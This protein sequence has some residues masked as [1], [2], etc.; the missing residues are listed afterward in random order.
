MPTYS[1][2]PL[3]TALQELSNRLFDSAQTFWSGPELTF[4]LQEALRTWNAMTGYWR[5]DF[6]FPA[7]NG[8][9]WYDLTDNVNLPNTLRPYTITDAYLYQIIQYHLL[10]P[11]TGVNPWTGVSNQFTAD[12]LINAVQRRRDEILAVCGCTLNRR[13]VPAVAG[14]TQLPDTVIDV[15][16]LS[17]QPTP[18]SLPYGRG[19]YGAG[20]Y[21][22]F[23]PNEKS[24]V[25]WPD[26][27][28]SERSF[29]RN[30]TINPAGTPQTY[31]MSTQPPIAF[32]T[33]APPAVPGNYELLTVEAGPLLSAATPHTLLIPDD[34][35]H[36]IKWG[37]L[38]DLLNRE[39][40]AKDQLR[41]KYCE[42]RYQ[43]GLALLASA[44]ALLAARIA[45]VA[46]QV[47][48]VRAADEFNTGWEAAAP[49][50]PQSALYAGLNLVA[51]TPI[52]DAGNYSVT[53]TVVENAP[54]PVV[55]GDFI[56]VSRDD[57]DVIIDYAQH[58]ASFKMGGAEFV[59][60]SPLLE[61][62]LAKAAV[63]GLKLSELGQYTSA[64]TALSQ[65]ETNLNPRM[66]PAPSGGP[67]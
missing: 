63:Y 9:T 13:L 3:S 25:V 61:R 67:A 47:D 15:R 52:P 35:T 14:R 10:E 26:D 53:A 22:Q 32:D 55:A 60:T 2:I 48:S 29:N 27:E 41:A 11:A 39:S 1:Y 50:M 58:L 62:F 20:P 33:D 44:P 6:T 49:G 46:I 16:R 65:Q 12:D 5:G 59:S 40:E 18:P 36:V 42:Q 17:Y 30:Y 56:Q 31:L 51:L 54:V 57:L 38:A 4:Y 7:R 37:A 8:I 34:W 19:F 43:M 64:I 28:W 23:A 21:G 45:N 66:A 24:S